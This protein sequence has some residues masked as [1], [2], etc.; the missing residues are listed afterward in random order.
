MAADRSSSGG[1]TKTRRGLSWP[2]RLGIVAASVVV[3]LAGL[4]FVITSGWF[5]KSFVLPR[6]GTAMHATM[7]AGDVSL[8]PL[9][10]AE[11]HQFTLRTTGTEPVVK[12]QELK[13]AY[14]LGA[15]MGGSIEVPEFSLVGP[16]VDIIIQP[17]G[18][19]NLD[20][21]MATNSQT[22]ASTKSSSKPLLVEIVKAAL[23][24]GKVRLTQ[25]QADG[26]KQ[27]IE[28]NNLEFSAQDVKN[29]KAG[30]MSL[31]LDLSQTRTPKPGSTNVPDGLQA[32]LRGNFDFQLDQQLLPSQVKGELRLAVTQGKGLY[33][34]LAGSSAIL[35]CDATPGEIKQLMLQFERAGQKLGALSVSG[36]FDA[37]KREAHVK[38]DIKDIDRQALNLVGAGIGLDFRDTKI[39]ASSVIDI[40]QRGQSIA[41]QGSLQVSQFGVTRGEVTTVPL[42]LRL[43]FGANADIAGKSGIV[44]ALNIKATQRQVDLLTGGLDRPMNFSWGESMHG[45]NEA[46]LSVNLNALNLDDWR[47]FLGPNPPSGIISIR[48]KLLTKKDARENTFDISTGI[49]SLTAA[50]G[51]NRLDRATVKLAAKGQFNDFK[52]LLLDE[53]SFS[54]AQ[55]GGALVNAKGSANVR[56]DTQDM[57]AQ[58]TLESDLPAVL[59]EF[60]VP[61]IAA[62]TGTLKVTGLYA[63]DKDGKHGTLNLVL[64]RFTGEAAG[65]KFAD[66]QVV[67]DTSGDY[68]GTRV[69]LRRASLTLR[70]GLQD[71]GTFDLGGTYDTD[72][73]SG[74][75]TFNLLNL[76]QNTLRTFLAPMLGQNELATG[77]IDLKG[78]TKFN[79]AE[80]STVQ[81]TLGVDK[82]LFTDP[83]GKFPKTPFSARLQLDA[84]QNRG[85]VQV[86]KAMLSLAPATPGS[87]EFQ[88]LGTLD[89]SNRVADVEFTL[90]NFTD[91]ALAPL[92]APALAPNRL[93]VFQLNAGG[94]AKYNPKGEGVIQLGLNLGGFQLADAKGVPTPPVPLKGEIQLQ[95]SQK[96]ALIE[97]QRLFVSLPP[98]DRAKNQFEAKGKLD[99]A[100][101][102]AA[103]SQ[104]TLAAESIDLTPVYDLFVT[105]K[106]PTAPATT[107]AKAKPA[108]KPA[109]GQGANASTQ[110]SGPPPTEP[111]PIALPLR[112]LAVDLKV[113]RLFLREIA[114]SNWVASVKIDN[115][116][117]ALS[118]FKLSLNGA[119]VTMDAWADLTQAGYRYK[120]GWSFDSVDLVPL[121]TSFSPDKTGQIQGLL[122][123]TAKIEGAGIT[124]PNLRRNL[125]GDIDFNLTNLNMQLVGPKAQK[126]LT[127]ISILLA[128]PEISATPLQSLGASATIGDGTVQLK[129]FKAASPAFIAGAT[130]TIELA[131]ILT[132]SP[133]NLPVSLSLKRNLAERARM[134][135][136][137]APADAQFVALPQFAKVTGTV[138]DPKTETDKTKIGGQLLDTAGQLVGGK[139]GGILQGVGGLF[140]G[141]AGKSVTNALPQTPIPAVPKTN[142]APKALDL[143]R[144]FLPPNKK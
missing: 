39:N 87:N 75:A 92:L 14:R 44:Q 91:T 42:D 45:L 40:L 41:A 117:V 103:P 126:L 78:T 56:L 52:T 2:K 46:T 132:N 93:A 79:P 95:A 32:S 143:I 20:A 101:T 142:E 141:D 4:Y 107:P 85:I 80:E 17:D 140:K 113:D 77:S 27:V 59:R 62:S 55:H 7:E 6:V 90:T 98:T 133:I 119:P 116:T 57:N 26:G 104:I 51:S 110:P 34:E 13:V 15:M 114:I 64:A 137:N 48:A 70:Q 69:D 76:N 37:A 131:D 74:T 38:I 82:V 84:S 106:A 54:L 112:N 3:V 89:L 61:Q 8:S 10:G 121:V 99:L 11:I 81:L 5:V 33:Q 125:K 139:A 66:W 1:E 128:V 21:L 100:A 23:T 86:R 71:G 130:G 53:Y 115:G 144:G 88:L 16:E 127:P 36:P 31:S 73:K 28:I 25:L 18:K 96:Q 29:A 68:K 63:Q 22:T 97:L 58:I 47:A 43:D 108:A 30:K 109:Q 102:N 94:K 9:S 136:A 129:H 138:G 124:G 120:A 134:L 49:D 118:P 111:P 105:N 50:F 65:Y 24:K 135:P 123:S 83:Q 19:S 60:P 67:F 122:R 12:I 72:L 35:T